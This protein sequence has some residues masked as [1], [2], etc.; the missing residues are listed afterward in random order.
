MDDFRDVTAIT[1]D[2]SAA[3]SGENLTVQ[4]DTTKITSP[5]GSVPTE[6]IPNDVNYASS[7]THSVAV[8]E[9]WNKEHTSIETKDT[10]DEGEHHQQEESQILL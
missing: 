6:Q 2:D 8:T 3:M 7:G 5:D 1:K 4:D 10:S 9:N